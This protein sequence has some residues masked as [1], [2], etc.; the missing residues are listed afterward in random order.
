MAA[1]AG[2][3][4]S[5]W[6]EENDGL[7]R[8]WRSRPCRVGAASAPRSAPGVGG[9]GGSRGLAGRSFPPGRAGPGG[10]AGAAP[11]SSSPGHAELPRRPD[12][13]LSCVQAAEASGLETRRAFSKLLQK[14]QG[15]PAVLP[16]LPLELTILCNSLLFDIGL[17]SESSE[18]LLARIDHG[19]NRVLEAHAVSGQGLTSEDR[20]QKVL[21]QGVP[22]ELQGPLHQLAALQ[23]LLWLAANHLRAAEGLFQ[24]LCSAE[25]AELHSGPASPLSP[26]LL[27]LLQGWH[28]SDLGE[29]DP[30]V[31]QRARDLKDVLWTSAAFLQG[32]QELDA[33]NPSAALAFL[34]KAATGLCPKRVLAQIFTLMGCCNLKMGKPQTAVQ[35]L[36]R[37]LQVDASFLPALYQAALLYRHLGFMEAELEA[38]ALLYQALDGPTQTAAESLSPS[39]LVG[40]ELLICTPRLR[41]CFGRNSLSE[42]KYLLAQR[43]LQAGR[44]REAAEHYLDLLALW[45]EGPLHQGLLCGELALPRIPEV[46]LEAASALEE[47]ARHRDAIAVCEEVVTQTSKLIPKS[48]RIDVGSSPPED[49]RGPPASSLTQQE[50]ERLHC[51]LW[52]AAAYLL[53]GCA[54]ARL[55]E[56]KEAV[57]LLSRCLHDLLRIQFVNTG[58]HS[59]EEEPALFAPSE[60]KVL[61]RIRQLALTVRGA[62]FLELG[63]DKEALMDFQ[64]SLHFCPESPAAHWYLLHTLW[65]L[66][67]RQEAL[68]H[69]QKFRMN[70]ALT[71]GEDERPC[72]QYLRL[73]MKWVRFPHTESLAKNLE[74]CLGESRQ[75]A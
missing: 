8:R 45:Q 35:C 20:W 34:Q 32:F 42:V 36:K 13:R 67:R 65:K 2:G 31:L 24:H 68:A 53:Q 9:P 64:H 21:Q 48:L 56:A 18:Q 15:L 44:A 37:A 28:P 62:E 72:P 17:S 54:W 19:L 49:S 29:S 14:I 60:A 46:F 59:T 47:T 26:G 27:S 50:R 43:C 3:C 39:S 6:R 33:G 61:P 5:L 63:R 66:D 10:G 40:V 75:E 25:V 16:A 58:S 51:A 38:L 11:R 55:G 74:T 70:P 52:R 71:E 7:V 30:L 1:A 4:L 22:E 12:P 73:C 23:G 69:W 57:G 41:T